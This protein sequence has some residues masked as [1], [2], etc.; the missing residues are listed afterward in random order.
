MN[1]KCVVGASGEISDFQELQKLLDE[2]AT[3]DYIA[4]DGIVSTPRE[5]HAYLC[6]VMYNRRNKCVSYF[7]QH[8]HLAWAPCTSLLLTTLVCFRFDPFWNSLVV[9]GMEGD[10]PF[11]G[12][13]SMIGVSY[14]GAYVCTGFANHLALPLIRDAHSPEMSEQ[15]AVDLV[16]QCLKVRFMPVRLCCTLQRHMR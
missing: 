7:W 14:T 16:Q 6:R 3:E 5:I 13:V 10:E 11:V 15:E 4:D 12:M 2:L 9:A 8:T 1:D